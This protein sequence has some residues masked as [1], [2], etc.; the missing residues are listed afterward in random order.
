VKKGIVLEVHDDHVTMLTPEGEFLQ[1]RKQKGQVG[2][3]EEIVFFPLHRAEKVKKGRLPSILRAKWAF[4]SLLTALVLV[5]LYPMFASNQVYAYV[6]LDVNP[7]IELGLNKDMKVI[8][9]DA[10][11]EEGEQIIRNIKNWEKKELT[12]VSNQLFEMFRQ[13]GYLNENSEVLIAS[14][15]TEDNKNWKE[16]MQAELTAL[17]EKIQQDKVSVTTLESNVEKRIDAIKHGMSPGKYIQKEQKT[18]LV[19][20]EDTSK[21][22]MVPSLP[23]KE[24][25]ANVKHVNAKNEENIPSITVSDKT[26][27][28]VKKHD[29]K[30]QRKNEINEKKEKI[31]Q[32]REEK[33]NQKEQVKNNRGQHEKQDHVKVEKKADLEQAKTD[34]KKKQNEKKQDIK[35]KQQ[36]KKQNN[37]DRKQDNKRNH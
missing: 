12:V 4:V 15:V 13:H 23:L 9:M 27:H 5:S 21:T 36:E 32:Q 2:I 7:S 16:K 37:K 17:S 26:D 35:G 8:Y 24:K 33:K 19:E 25:P 34:K 30:E 11:N 22:E 10:Y 14:T 31:D 3:G 20:K 28:K 29:R 1:S 6:S 18:E